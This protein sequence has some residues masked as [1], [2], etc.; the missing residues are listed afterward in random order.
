MTAVLAAPFVAHASINDIFRGWGWNSTNTGWISLN[1]V[2]TFAANDYG[3][4][5]DA[6]K[7]VTGWAW[8]T[9]LGWLCFGSTCNTGSPPNP[10]V[11]VP[12]APVAS[13]ALFNDAVIPAQLTGWARIYSLAKLGGDQG[14]ISLNCSNMGSCATSNYHVDVDIADGFLKG[15]G[16]NK[17]A[18]GGVYAGGVGWVRFDPLYPSVP[19]YTPPYVGGVT[20]APWLQAL[21]GDIY[22]KGDITTPTPFS[23][24][25]QRQNATFCL[26]K[27]PTSTITNFTQGQCG[28]PSSGYNFN[29]N[30]GLSLPKSS[31][32]YSS[33]LGR[34]D[35]A[36]IRAG[37]FGPVVAVSNLDSSIPTV[38]G[39]SVY[40]TVTT[41]DYNWS[42]TTFQNA[43][44]TGSG[45]GLLIVVG[46]LS[47]NGNINYQ[48]PSPPIT[49]LKQ[50]ASFGIL[51]LD[52]GSGTKGNVTIAPSVTN[53]GAN[54][55]A[56]GTIST[57]TTTKPKTEQPLVV[58]GVVIAK[59]FR[60]ER[61]YSGSQPSEQ[62]V[63]D[64]RI[65]ANTPPGMSD[66]VQALPKLFEG[67]PQ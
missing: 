35:L 38:L 49:N 33:T 7:N 1:A 44:G 60:F 57:G 14:W 32:K 4:T 37:R 66:F 27:G 25:L 3:V 22:S 31:T 34:I 54:I 29:V 58:S 42:G 11:D 52:D 30:T 59:A 23:T 28:N 40:D 61:E 46:N 2:N 63:Y 16:W 41:N 17:V 55:Y 53:I 8:S 45:A 48:T 18:S 19:P 12:G 65:V 47:I 51:V 26:D 62:I 43:T 15:Y 5:I 20:G 36:G 24:L 13:W 56:E 9:N 6:G 39:G 21:F 50:L 10:A 64:G 67:L